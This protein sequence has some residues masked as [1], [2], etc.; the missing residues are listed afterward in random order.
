MFHFNIQFWTWNLFQTNLAVLVQ[1]APSKVIRSHKFL[2]Q[3]LEA[4]FETT[5]M[6]GWNLSSPTDIAASHSHHCFVGIFQIALFTAFW[7]FWPFKTG[8]GVVLAARWRRT[9]NLML[10]TA[11]VEH[12]FLSHIL[13]VSQTILSDAT[14]VTSSTDSSTQS[15]YKW[16]VVTF[17]LSLTIKNFN[18]FSAGSNF[19]F[20]FPFIINFHLFDHTDDP[21][22]Q[23]FQFH[24]KCITK[25][26][27]LSFWVHCCYRRQGHLKSL[28]CKSSLW[29]RI[30]PNWQAQ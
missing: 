20:D 21:I 23:Q 6:S 29:N 13:A 5:P 17:Y 25:R 30:Q 4:V 22:T 1:H 16:S 19:G 26:Q 11:Q 27:V 24:F 10:L 7:Q 3:K 18:C 2:G 8:P 12:G 15:F 9:L 28:H 14:S